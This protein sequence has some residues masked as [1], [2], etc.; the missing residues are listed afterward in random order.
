MANIKPPSSPDDTSHVLD[1]INPDGLLGGI[2]L[3]GVDTGAMGLDLLMDPVDMG[4]AGADI[5]AWASG[6]NSLSGQT[7]GPDYSVGPVG[8]GALHLYPDRLETDHALLEDT[9]VQ[10]LMGVI[11]DREGKQY[12][13]VVGGQKFDDY[14]RH[15]NIKVG[16]SHA[17][18]AYQ[19]QPGTWDP[20]RKALHL[21]DFSPASQDLA[22]VDLLRQKGA[23]DRL[24]SDDFDGAVFAAS[25][26]W[27]SLPHQTRQTKDVHGRP[28]GTGLKN[29]KTPTLAQIRAD[30]LKRLR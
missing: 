25:V 1:G 8:A 11:R 21:P 12:N 7:T 3:S 26:P 19:M 16:R 18:G 17:A 2:A 24:L 20:I 27:R 9:R 30:Y 13:V 28:Y 22:A 14:A 6:D 5:N 23:T 10:A 29:E 15:P 4:R